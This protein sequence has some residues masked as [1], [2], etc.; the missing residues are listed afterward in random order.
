MPPMV[1]AM[2]FLY[3]TKGSVSLDIPSKIASVSK[4]LA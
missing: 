4:S 3:A 1:I 2:G